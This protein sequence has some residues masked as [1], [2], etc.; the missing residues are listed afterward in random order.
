MK[1]EKEKMLAG[2]L[3]RAS[4]PVL[5]QEHLAAQELTAEYNRTLPH[6][7]GRREALL[8]KL[9][10]GAGIAPFVEPDFHCDYGYNIRVGD[11]FYANFGCIILDVAPVIFGDDCM[12]GPRVSVFT[13]GHPLDPYERR[14]GLEYGKPVTVGNNVWIGGGAI[15]NP[16][17]T[18]GDNA[19][20]A[21]GAVVTKDIPP[22]SLA[23]GV[24]AKVI[25]TIKPRSDKN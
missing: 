5:V 7:R 23:A 3:Y 9:F 10:G 4:D 24:P 18:I 17:V 16:G 11:R 8:R 14:S 12:L 19:V 2:E 15:L 13:A 1:S 22:N 20:I 21:S 25:K 6:E